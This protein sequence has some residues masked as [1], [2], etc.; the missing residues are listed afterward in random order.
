MV[1]APVIVLS[2]LLAGIL[3]PAQGVATTAVASTPEVSCGAPLP[4]AGAIFEGTVLHVP[5]GRTLCVAQ[6]PTPDRWVRVTLSNTPADA[7]RRDLM[8]AAFA[9]RA[10]CRVVGRSGSGV[11]A[12]CE[13]DG[14]PLNEVLQRPAVRLAAFFWR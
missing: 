10:V 2:V 12:Q 11:V 6:G 14:A 5:D 1:R 8:S 3:V 9:K 7:P 4:A 13:V